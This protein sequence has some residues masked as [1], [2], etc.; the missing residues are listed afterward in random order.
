MNKEYAKKLIDK[1]ID[2]YT[3]IADLWSSKRW[4]LTG[5]LVELKKY[6]GPGAKVLD[7]GCGNGRLSELFLNTEIDYLG[8]DPSEGLIDIAKNK[9]P[10]AKFT[11]LNDNL[12]GTKEFDTIYCLTVIHHVAGKDNRKKFVRRL[13]DL[14]K[15]NGTLVI[16]TWNLSTTPKDYR[17]KLISKLKNPRLDWGD[18]F[19]PFKNSL[20][21]I[22]VDRYIHAFSFKEFKK[23]LTESGFEIIELRNEPRGKGKFTNFLAICKKKK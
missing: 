13:L 18:I 22:E 21:E 4:R 7:F 10:E 11:V 2:D 16:S 3:R 14:L 1:T 23:I 6:A 5:D 19:Y 9:Y 8:V 20:G 12:S 15:D 17:R